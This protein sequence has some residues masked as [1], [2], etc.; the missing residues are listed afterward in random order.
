MPL[1]EYQ[2]N[3]CNNIIEEFH[4]HTDII[5]KLF[6]KTCNNYCSVKKII[7]KSTFKLEGEGW[8]KDGYSKQRMDKFEHYI[9]E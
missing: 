9:K 1:Y 4:K 7:S 6:C 2:C 8:G 5:N 3:K